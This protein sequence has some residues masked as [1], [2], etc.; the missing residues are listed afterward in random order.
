[1]KSS[2]DAYGAKGKGNLLPFDP[3][4][5]VL[6]TDKKSPLYDE[7]MELPINEALV[8]NIMHHGVLKPI[9]VRK[10]TE[11][12]KLEVVDG[13]QRVR[14]CREANK[15]L[16]KKGLEPH[17]IKAEVRRG[18]APATMGIMMSANEFNQ[19]PSAMERARKIQ[20]YLELGRTPEECSVLLGL[21]T[22][23]IKNLIGLLDATAAVRNAVDAG[24]VNASVG[25]KLAK[26]S[27]DEQKKKLAQL[28]KAAPMNGRAGKRGPNKK[29]KKIREI[30]GDGNAGVRGKKEIKDLYKEIE[31]S[32]EIKPAHRR[33][34]L[35]T[36]DWVLGEDEAMG[37]FFQRSAAESETQEDETEAEEEDESEPVTGL[38]EEDEAEEALA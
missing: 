38:P 22:A 36:L 2:K 30:L 25:Y 33:V 37:G 34:V 35:C 7:R 20:R 21:G 17:W 29:A 28:V 1:M 9:L 4:D 26:L 23:T 12:G 3:E 13:R 24:K 31:E 8:L 10:N 27:A 6:V 15:R 16:K 32:E 18:D 11:T 19:A 5:L 14:A